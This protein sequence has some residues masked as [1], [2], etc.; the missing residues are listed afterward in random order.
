MHEFEYLQRSQLFVQRGIK[1]IKST[2]DMS[3]KPLEVN[4]RYLIIKGRKSYEVD[5]HYSIYDIQSDAVGYEF[6]SCVFN[7]L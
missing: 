4:L 5:F 1:T 6:F 2:Q 7:A 3:T